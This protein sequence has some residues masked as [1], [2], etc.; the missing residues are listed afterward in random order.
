MAPQLTEEQHR[1]VTTQPGRVVY[2]VDAATQQQYA[3]IPAET[4]QKVQAL[5]DPLEMLD[6]RE[7][8]PL[9]D[10]AWQAILD[11]AAL[12]VYEDEIPAQSQP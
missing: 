3:V 4:F 5:F 1:A 8:Y 7:I 10:S 11:D 12:D 6:P 2:F 9:V